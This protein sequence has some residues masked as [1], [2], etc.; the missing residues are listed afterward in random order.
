[1]H[2][3]TKIYENKRSTQKGEREHNQSVAQRAAQILE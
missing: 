2:N 1:M 3:S